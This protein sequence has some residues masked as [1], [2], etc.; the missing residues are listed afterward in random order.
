MKQLEELEAKVLQVIQKNVELHKKNSELKKENEIL[1]SKC[2]Q[3]EK[4]LMANN[5]ASNDLQ[6]EKTVIMDSIKDLL[7][8]I[9]S[10]EEKN[11][12]IVK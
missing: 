11:K 9:S 5:K 7:E 12:E 10:L 4:S 3:L 8:T 2:V 1:S 6:D